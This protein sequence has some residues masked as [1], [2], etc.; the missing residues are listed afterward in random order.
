MRRQDRRD[1]TR[2]SERLR[3]TTEQ[4]WTDDPRLNDAGGGPDC[5]DF[6][7]HDDSHHHHSDSHYDLDGDND[8]AEQW[9]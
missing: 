9:V 2:L 7:P 6:W 8:G 5:D 4:R 1:R 3:R